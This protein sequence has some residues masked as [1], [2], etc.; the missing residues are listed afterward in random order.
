M[1]APAACCAL[2]PIEDTPPRCHTPTPTPTNWCSGGRAA[3]GADKDGLSSYLYLR[4][5]CVLFFL[6]S[7]FLVASCLRAAL[8]PFFFLFLPLSPSLYMRHSSLHP[9]VSMGCPSQRRAAASSALPRLF[10]LEGASRVCVSGCDGVFAGSDKMA[11]LADLFWFRSFSPSTCHWGMR[12]AFMCLAAASEENGPCTPQL[13]TRCG[14]CF[15]F[16][17]HR[18]RLEPRST[19]AL[20]PT[21]IPPPPVLV[22]SESTVDNSEHALRASS[23]LVSF[24]VFLVALS[25]SHC[26]PSPCS[27]LA[28]STRL[29][30]HTSTDSPCRDRLWYP[31]SLVPPLFRLFPLLF[32]LV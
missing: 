1:V 2:P 11:P 6:L 4:R 31:P 21:C 10:S 30:T 26:S 17:K 3:P 27:P 9:L 8:L 15:S 12:C 18:G 23:F 13:Y 32:P 14:T 5:L 7:S 25:I 29:Y 28:Q 22:S 16:L 24:S 20:R 19:A